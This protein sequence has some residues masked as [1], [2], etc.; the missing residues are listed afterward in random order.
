MAVEKHACAIALRLGPVIGKAV[1][2]LRQ[3]KMNDAP[4]ASSVKTN[5]RSYFGIGLAAE[6]MAGTTL[7]QAGESG[8]SRGSGLRV[9]PRF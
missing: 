7:A 6:M 1:A 9:E 4:G 8:V 3:N 5:P 2:S